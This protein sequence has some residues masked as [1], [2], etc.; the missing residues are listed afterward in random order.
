MPELPKQRIHQERLFNQR[1]YIPKNPVTGMRNMQPVTV[2]IGSLVFRP[3]P[4][5]GSDHSAY[6]PNTFTRES[7]GCLSTGAAAWATVPNGICACNTQLGGRPNS[8]ETASSISG[9]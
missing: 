6:R 9:L 4:V 5:S 3:H 8:A 2:F 1:F 7:T